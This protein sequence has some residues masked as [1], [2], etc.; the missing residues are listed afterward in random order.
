MPLG[1]DRVVQRA[2][3]RDAKALGQRGLHRSHGN[4][5]GPF[6]ANG[7]VVFFLLAV[8][9]HREGKILGRIE[10]VQRFFQLE[11]V[12]T[13][14]NVFAALHEARHDLADLR[15][16]QRLSA[17]DGHHRCP[18]FL[19]S[20]EALLRRQMPPQRFHRML[21]FA[22]TETRQVTAKQRLEHQH[23]WVTLDPAHALA[24]HVAGDG[25]HLRKWYRHYQYLDGLAATR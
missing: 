16:E 11:R 7:Q 20:S 17:G 18:A 19:G 4:L 2:V 1:I 14:V 8:Q 22:T 23:Q 12:G 5:V 10:Q 3:D 21:D 25:E 9:M 15:V 6:P 13:Q 24:K